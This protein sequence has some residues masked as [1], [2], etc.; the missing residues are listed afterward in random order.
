MVNIQ[1]RKQISDDKDELDE[2]LKRGRP[3]GAGN[4]MAED[5]SALLDLVEKELPLGQWGWQ[6]IHCQF[7]KWARLNCCPERALKSLETKYK[8]VGPHISSSIY[9]SWCF[10]LVKV[11][12]PTGD[13]FCPPDVKRAHRIKQLINERAC[14]RDISESEFED[15]HDLAADDDE[16][17]ENKN[18][19][20][21]Q[22]KK[23]STTD[24]AIWSAI[25]HGPEPSVQWRTSHSSG[26]ELIT[27]LSDAF[28]PAVQQARDEECANCSF[29]SVQMMTLSQQLRDANSNI[30]N[31]HQQITSL[32]AQVYEAEWRCNLAELKLEMTEHSQNQQFP[33]LGHHRNE[34]KPCHQ[35]KHKP[36]R[37]RLH[38][39]PATK[40]ELVRV[41]GKTRCVEH[42]PEGGTHTYWVTDPS[43]E[44]SSEEDNVYQRHQA[45]RNHR[46]SSTS[47]NQAYSPAPYRDDNAYII[48]PPA[49]SQ[50]VNIASSDVPPPPPHPP[51]LCFGI[52]MN[53]KY[54]Y[55]YSNSAYVWNIATLSFLLCSEK[56]C[57]RNSSIYTLPLCFHASRQS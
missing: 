56:L 32:Q 29:Q 53:G 42:F 31:L 12:K 17:K 28:D 14:T 40:R 18:D 47:S 41:N 30:E 48:Q 39:S 37:R 19:I 46:Y 51:P 16:D 44:E 35:N 23:S 10:Q 52:D 8:Q 34:H 3:H 27:K 24:K 36:H 4:Y 49:P 25:I 45:H 7:T 6:T 15:H 11:T 13:A 33:A 43:T 1:K 55:S 9:Y 20:D 22:L 26:V 21:Q 54:I 57:L 5:V 38:H 2:G 50:S